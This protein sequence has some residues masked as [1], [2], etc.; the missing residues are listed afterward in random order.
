MRLIIATIFIVLL[1]LAQSIDTCYHQTAY[2][3]LNVECKNLDYM[4]CIYKL[5]MTNKL[6]V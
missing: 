6:G 4:N 3:I 2:N 5:R 1:S